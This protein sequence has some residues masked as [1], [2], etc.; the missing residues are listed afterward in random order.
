MLLLVAAVVAGCSGSGV[1]DAAGDGAGGAARDAA[2]DVV[3]TFVR[4]N[5]FTAL[6]R[7]VVLLG[8]TDATGPSLRVAAVVAD[9]SEAQAR[10]LMGVGTVPDGV[11]MLFVLPDPPGPGG[12]PGFWM[13]GTLTPLDI[14]FAA[15]GVIVGVATMEPCPGLPCPITH[16]GADYDVAL[17]VVAG[18]LAAAGIGPGDRLV[19]TTD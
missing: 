9:T 3:D 8:G 10:G 16:P 15:G 6:P 12:R 5:G 14:A 2:G 4:D 17:E 18:A 13:L 11:G 1:P 7:A 19:W